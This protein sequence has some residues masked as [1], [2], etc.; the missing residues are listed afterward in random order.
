MIQLIKKF[1]TANL[2]TQ[3]II[4]L[5]SLIS[6]FLSSY[7]LEV[8]YK[9]SKFP[10]PYF[11][12]QTSFNAKNIKTW[13][14]FMIQKGTFEI[15]F[16]TQIIDFVFIA[17][18]ILAGFTIWAFL[19]NLFKKETFFYKWGHIFAFSLPFAG[20]FDILENVVSFIMIA[21]PDNF[22]NI[23]VIPYSLF[24]SIKFGFWGLG[25][26]WL[27]ILITALPSV[28]LISKK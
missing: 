8:S 21:K 16:K 1:R 3:G 28:Q 15:Y 22:L 13:Y 23:L 27:V 26:I 24:A 20:F 4:A 2:K 11:V 19:V 5:A 14:A 17:T 12:Q 6:Y 25:L 18:V 9:Q 10:V 7:F